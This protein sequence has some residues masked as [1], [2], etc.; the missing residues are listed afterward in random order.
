MHCYQ[1]NDQEDFLVIYIYSY[2]KQS[3]LGM[4][5]TCVECMSNML[6]RKYSMSMP[7]WSLPSQH[8][9]RDLCLRE[10]HSTGFCLVFSCWI[11]FVVSQRKIMDTQR[12]ASNTLLNVCFILLLNVFLCFLPKK[13]CTNRQFSTEG[14]SP[15]F[16]VWRFLPKRRNG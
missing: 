2:L 7:I 8:I 14:I 3:K 16:K 4:F 12:Q 11:E 10:S 9:Q 13:R 5:Q 6:Q 1:S 15:G